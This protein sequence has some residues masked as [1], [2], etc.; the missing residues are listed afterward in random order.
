MQM[1]TKLVPILLLI[2]QIAS[3][4]PAIETRTN[5]NKQYGSRIPLALDSDT[6]AVVTIPQTRN[7]FQLAA[8]DVQILGM[9][10]GQ[11]QAMGLNLMMLMPPPRPAYFPAELTA[12]VAEIEAPLTPNDYRA[13]YTATIRTL[14]AL[15]IAAPNL[16]ALEVP[17]RDMYFLRDM[18]W[19]P[20]TSVHAAR[21][22]AILMAGQDARAMPALDQETHA[23]GHLDKILTDLCAFQPLE[24]TS[25]T[26]YPTYDGGLFDDPAPTVAYA[27]TSFSISLGAR[28]P[29]HLGY[30]SKTVIQDF[31]VKGGGAEGPI[32]AA[33]HT[34]LTTENSLDTVVW[35]IPYINSLSQHGFVRHL[36]G[37]LVRDYAYDG[38]DPMPVA[39]KGWTVINEW[40]AEGALLVEVTAPDHAVRR[41]DFAARTAEGYARR[42][43]IRSTRMAPEHRIDQFYLVLTADE[44]A[45]LR[46]LKLTVHGDVGQVPVHVRTFSLPQAAL[47]PVLQ[48]AIAD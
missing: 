6:G 22:L 13:N 12:R 39:S 34:A 45:G 40:P 47:S 25:T 36:L 15:G 33:I 4:C 11:F 43:V 10:R 9:L 37:H 8:S 3:A 14:N 5:E 1:L 41:V 24:E 27:G 7:L 17:D 35:E 44:V 16:M 23:I 21:A 29:D 20:K 48:A 32:M 42:R 31:S 18:H 30:F 38:T 28:V 2:G 46:E 19:K 26:F